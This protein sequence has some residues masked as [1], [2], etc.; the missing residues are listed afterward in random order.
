M[1]AEGYWIMETAKFKK[2]IYYK[3]CNFKM[4]V[5]KYGLLAEKF[6]L[7]LLRKQK[8]KDIFKIKNKISFDQK[9][10][11]ESLDFRQK[12]RKK[13]IYKVGP[14][15]RFLGKETALILDDM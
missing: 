5:R 15:K 6:C 11:M 7:C 9:R 13:K 8:I 1:A 3:K 2:A 12:E 14:Y 4:E 10:P